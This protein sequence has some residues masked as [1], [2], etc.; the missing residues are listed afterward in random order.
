MNQLQ[1]AEFEILKDFDAFCKK[2]DIKYMLYAGTLLGA[3]R[4]QGF[5]PWDD[6]IDICMTREEYERFE[7]LYLDSDEKNILQT[8]FNVPFYYNVHSKLRNHSLPVKENTSKTQRDQI[9]PWIDLFQYDNIP[10]DPKERLDH[11]NEVKKVNQILRNLLFTKAEHTNG[12]KGKI[13]KAVQVINEKLYRTY[14]FIPYLVRK[15]HKLLTKYNHIETEYRGIPAFYKNY[16][17]Y[18]TT[19]IKNESFNHFIDVTFEIDEFPGPKNYDECLTTMYGDYMTI[20]KVEDQV[21]HDIIEH[22]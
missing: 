17:E 4:H 20:P 7:K 22:V 19:F 5:I 12:L 16:H 1:Q 21:R 3:V 10:D 6:D 9:G 13:K 18:E 11:F 14:F 8:Q 15:R 2:H